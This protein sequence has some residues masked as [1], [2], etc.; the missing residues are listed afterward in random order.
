MAPTTISKQ[1]PSLGGF[2]ITGGITLAMLIIGLLLAINDPR[3]PSTLL[4]IFS[5]RFL[6]I[7]IEALP[8]LVLGTLVSGLI[9]AFVRQEDVLRWLPRNR[10]LATVGGAFMGIIFPVCECGVVPVARRLFTKGLPISVGVSFLLAAP[11][12]NP[13]V[14]ASTYIAF[15][16]GP[17]F[18]MR[19][20][21]TAIVAITV[22][23][24]FAFNRQP[25][26]LLQPASWQKEVLHTGSRRNWR[27]G[28]QYTVA[29]ASNEFF[30][31]G[32]YLYIGCLL[33]ATMQTFIPQDALLA[34]GEGPVL[35]VLVMQALAF[36]LSI[37][38]TVDSF[39]VLAFV[40]TFTT[41][42]IVSFLTFGPMVDI[43]STMMFMGVFK[44][45]TVLYLVLLPFVLNLLAGVLINALGGS[46]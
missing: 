33:A 9:E 21:V 29:I 46:F 7:L 4:S 18:I 5:T 30:E 23:L 16:F 36:I 22:G 1:T 32:R 19:F 42:S 25:E 15:G 44:R 2:V 13:I 17:I 11:F 40:N 41:G 28:L 37:C 39:F 12:M 27:E 3:S 14:F 8:F 6:G 26:A 10:Y 24:I 34:I 35:S 45:R 43:K 31:M 20:V 38:S